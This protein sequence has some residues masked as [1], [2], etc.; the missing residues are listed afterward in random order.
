MPGFDS[1]HGYLYIRLPSGQGVAYPLVGESMRIGRDPAA[2]INID[3]PSLD[4]HHAR[5]HFQGQFVGLED[6][7]SEQGTAIDNNRLLANRIYVVTDDA[8]IRLGVVFARWY[9]TRANLPA[10]AILAGSEAETLIAAG[11]LEPAADDA[12]PENSDDLT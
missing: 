11:A 5:L 8:R 2:E 12:P 6:L 10:D 3:H 4:I 1:Q 7:G 9:E